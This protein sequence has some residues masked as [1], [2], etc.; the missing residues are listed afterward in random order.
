MRTVKCTATSTTQWVYSRVSKGVSGKREF[1][2]IRLETFGNSRP[3]KFE[4]RSPETIGDEPTFGGPFSSEDGNALKRTLSGWR[5]SVYR[6]RL[7]ANSLQ[8]GILQGILRF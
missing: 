6:T 4:H 1:S 8:Q 7:Q 3:E 5:R 2:W